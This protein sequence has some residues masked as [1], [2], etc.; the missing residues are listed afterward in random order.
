MKMKM[1]ATEWKELVKKVEFEN[2]EG[3]EP[4]E[5]VRVSLKSFFTVVSRDDALFGEMLVL[6]LSTWGHCWDTGG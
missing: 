2:P 3:N 6:L 4:I 5:A 1:K